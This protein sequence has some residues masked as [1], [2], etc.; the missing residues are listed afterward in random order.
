MVVR[1]SLHVCHVVVLRDNM[2]IILTVKTID[3][4][5]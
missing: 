2:D 1:G 3:V 5:E 4:C